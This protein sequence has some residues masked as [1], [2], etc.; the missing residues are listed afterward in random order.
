[1]IFLSSP[2]SDPDPLVMAKRFIEVEELTSAML[3][4]GAV[5]FS[6]IVY[7]HE[8]SKKYNLPKDAQYW[9]NFN[10]SMLRRCDLFAILMLDGWE[11]SKGVQ[12]ELSLAKHL[13][14][15]VQELRKVE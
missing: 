7:L 8:I 14:I 13:N 15:P 1:M 11:Q 10:V 5:V 4:Q 9:S 12:M 2:Y 6:P 3:K